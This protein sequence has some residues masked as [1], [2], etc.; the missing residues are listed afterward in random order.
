MLAKI[1]LRNATFGFDKIYTYLVPNELSA[2]VQPGLRIMVPFGAGN[3]LREC[4]VLETTVATEE[5]GSS[6]ALKELDA[7]CDPVPVLKPDQLRLAQQM[8]IRYVATWGEIM[9]S[10]LPPGLMSTADKGE[11]MRP[12]R[13]RTVR[14]VD[15]E[16]ATEL[17]E[18]EELRFIQQIRV[19]ELLLEY[20]EVTVAECRTLCQISD[21]PL[22]TLVKKG[23]VVYGWR[24]SEAEDISAKAVTELAPHNIENMPLTDDQDT[25]MNALLSAFDA[26]DGDA[27][28]L[29]E[30][31]LHG[32]TGSGKTEVYL[33]LARKVLAAGRGVI[34]LVPEISLTPQMVARITQRF[35]DEVAV[36]HSMLTARQRFDQWLRILRGEVRLVVGARSAVFSPVDNLGLIVIDEEQ[37]SAYISERRPCY[38]ARTVGRLRCVNSDALLLLGSATPSVESYYRTETGRSRLLQLSS[39]PGGA[40]LPRVEIA[41]MRKEERLGTSGLISMSLYKLLAETLEQGRQSVVLLNRRGYSAA[42][43]CHDCGAG[44]NCPA[45]SVNMRWHAAGRRLMCHYCGRIASLPSHCPNCGSPYI[46][47]V[48]CG[49]QQAVSAIAELLPTARI[50]RMD[51][52]AVR[53]E[54][55]GGH[56]E[57]LRRFAAGEADILVGTQMI[58]RGHDFPDVAAVGVLMADLTLN[59]PD[60]R[61]HEEAFRLFTQAA[62]R[63]GR[64]TAGEAGIGR[65]IIQ[66]FDADNL[67]L[68]AALHHDYSAFYTNE[69]AFRRQA[70]YPPFKVLASVRINGHIERAVAER[71]QFL[72][73]KAI[74]L[75]E[76]HCPDSEIIFSRATRS[77]I[78]QLSR[79]YRWQFMLTGDDLAGITAI[80]QNLALLPLRKD[81]KGITQSFEVDP[82]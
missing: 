52:D 31:L 73:E 49:T 50:L 79:R 1:V 43:V 45:C 14:L 41:D 27:R 70:G 20:G 64:S 56:A 48:G 67:T 74:K 10:M 57:L 80:L 11:G 58:A 78:W 7:I 66:A 81:E 75:R 22:N 63:A 69:L 9:R 42:V 65:V 16:A 47:A 17:L 55:R 54:G 62:G 34:I 12:R 29:R 38:D 59:Q 33:R 19:L 28:R 23:I 25:V 2:A 5:A 26:P 36:Q 3:R 68:Q 6:Y 39:R 40:H 61:A 8:K 37:E 24:E 71:T 21:S 15:P 76:Q 4:F 82:A 53:D 72:C 51:Q 18:G 77:G 35:G 30:F 46:Q 60:Y 13:E 32:V 44:I